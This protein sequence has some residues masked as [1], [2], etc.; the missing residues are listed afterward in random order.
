MLCSVILV[1][2]FCHTIC[3]TQACETY[4]CPYNS[5][6]ELQDEEFMKISLDLETALAPFHF[7]WCGEWCR[8]T[9]SICQAERASGRGFSKIKQKYRFATIQFGTIK[10]FAGAVVINNPE[11]SCNEARTQTLLSIFMDNLLKHMNLLLVLKRTSVNHGARSKDGQCFGLF[12][13]FAFKSSYLNYLK[14]KT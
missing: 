11:L 6:A 8:H 9:I 3:Y 10:R 12:I 7:L 4:I 13:K 1:D 2:C 5:W 14:N